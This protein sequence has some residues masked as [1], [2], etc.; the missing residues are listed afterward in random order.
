LGL[1][2]QP[3]LTNFYTLGTSPMVLMGST[4]DYVAG[5]RG[6]LE[7][8]TVSNFASLAQNQIFFI[9]GA[10][11]ASNSVSTGLATPSGTYYARWRIVQ[12]SEGGGVITG[13]DT[14]GNPVSFNANISAWSNTVT[15]TINVATTQLSSANKSQYVTP[16]GVPQLHFVGTGGVGAAEEIFADTTKTGLIRVFELTLTTWGANPV[17]I[18]FDDGVL[19]GTQNFKVPGLTGGVPGCSFAQG[20]INSNGAQVQGSPANSSVAQGDTLTCVIDQTTPSSVSASFYRTRAG[21][22]VQIGTTVTGITGLSGGSRP[23]VAPY[24]GDTGDVN[25]GQNAFVR[26]LGGSEV[27]FG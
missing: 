17:L 14:A 1:I 22:T 15:D 8:S 9:D 13:N 23:C 21:V 20:A 6:Q 5:L 10:S 2:A 16:S 3:S 12:D 27:M 11:W 19:T 4:T 24:Q 7:I 26:T 25:F 18:G